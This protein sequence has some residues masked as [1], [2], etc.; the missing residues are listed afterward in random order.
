MSKKIQTTQTLVIVESPSKCKKIED[1]LGPGYKC[2]ASFG[3]LRELK[4]LEYI[5][6]N[7]NFKPNFTVI[8]NPLKKKQIGIIQ[9]E[10]NKS[11]DIILA[12]DDDREGEAISWHICELFNLD[13][14]KTKRIVFNEITETAIQTAI[15]NPRTIDMNIVKAQHTRQILDLLVGFK[16]SPMLWKHISRTSENSLSAGRCQTPALKIVYENQ[17]EI[18]KSPG[19]EM[20]NTTGYFTSQNIPFQLDK[21]FISADELTDFLDKSIKF[22][23]IY[24]CSKPRQ[25]VKKCPDPFTT[26]RLQQ[27]A[28]NELHYSPKETMK[29]CQKLYESGYITYMRTDS[30]KYSKEFIEEIGNYI[31]R[32]Y[33]ANY[34]NENINDLIN[35]SDENEIKERK[36]K[37]K[38]DDDK[39]TQNAHEAI[40]PTN[41]SLKELPEEM[42][43]KE[44]RMYKLIWENTIESCMKHSIF[45]SITASIKGEM[46]TIFKYTSEKIDFLGWKIVE[47]NGNNE[48]ENDKYYQYLL[49][50]KEN[51]ILPYKKI[52]S[53]VTLKNNKTH[54][55]EARLVQLLE[56]KGIGRP[57]TFSSL[58]DKI[59]EKGYVKKEN[60]K[61]KEIVCKDYELEGEDIF[62]IETKREFGNEKNKLVIQNLGVIVMEYLDTNFQELFDYN[63]TKDMEEKLDKIAHNNDIWHVVCSNYYDEIKKLVGKLDDMEKLEIKIDD[64]HSYI[65]GKHGPTIKCVEDG[66]I[67]FKSVKKDID[68]ARL[69]NCEYKL[70][71]II[72]ETKKNDNN[73]GKFEGKDLYLKKGKYGLYAEWGTNKKSMKC[74]GNRPIENIEYMEVL[75]ILEEYKNYKNECKS[76]SSGSDSENSSKKRQVNINI[77]RE[78]SKNITIRKGKGNDYIFYK[79]KDM[80]KPQ[81]YKLNEFKEDYK[82]CDKK[83]LKSWIQEKYNII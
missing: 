35:N 64:K 72:T 32:N 25:V 23:H 10:I 66:N 48:K 28:S 37:K 83:I 46:D 62:E 42:E 47:Y 39:L 22:N 17:K 24:N 9:S 15:K 43:N 70:E 33:D 52:V 12:T 18:E 20:Y 2:I 61:G 7:N 55:T 58:I 14:K 56:E 40:R 77:V 27:V 4:S 79:T 81:F 59:Q 74:F 31:S 8:D 68:I 69:K 65:I 11:G 76:G 63:Y 36:D 21:E 51:M 53:K 50:I 82:I 6:F 5:D 49:T 19:I 3:H 34:I 54:Y 73:I 1:Y 80:T 75:K 71:E 57:S 78:I 44:K 67:S 60:V 30:K 26:S 41:I 38:K 13:I 29:L 16:I 45:L